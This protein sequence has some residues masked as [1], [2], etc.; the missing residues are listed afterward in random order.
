[1]SRP[2]RSLAGADALLERCSQ[3]CR[4]VRPPAGARAAALAGAAAGATALAHTLLTTP[5]RADAAQQEGGGL[6]A[7]LH[8]HRATLGPI[9]F[10]PTRANGDGA[11]S[12][13]DLAISTPLLA[14]P[15]G[16]VLTADRACEA[17][18]V[19]ADA[20]RA[21]STRTGSP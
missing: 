7:W 6:A 3:R 10:A 12:T 13:Q 9:R 16:L 14:L 4:V 15:A 17:A 20:M 1:M 11:F 8:G 19:G 21:P 5:A 2:F 18:E